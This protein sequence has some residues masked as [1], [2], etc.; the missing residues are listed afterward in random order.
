[1]AKA[2]TSAT[3]EPETLPEETGGTEDQPDPQTPSPSQGGIE[4]EELPLASADD[5]GPE[6]GW[7]MVSLP[8]LRKRV[9][10]RYAGTHEITYLSL[11]PDMVDFARFAVRAAARE[12][13]EED[14]EDQEAEEKDPR[15]QDTAAMFTAENIRWRQRLAHLVVM[16]PGDTEPSLC[17]DC[18]IIHPPSLWSSARTQRLHGD[19]LL[20]IAEASLGVREFRTVRPFSK[21]KTAPDSAAPVGTS[22]STPPT[23]SA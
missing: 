19:D 18:R 3:S 4:S 11:L 7:E 13:Q 8:R 1:M 20:A 6:Q 5:L 12:E 10:V 17:A 9:Q 21:E 15:E 23:S 2:P 16:N 14:E 22:E